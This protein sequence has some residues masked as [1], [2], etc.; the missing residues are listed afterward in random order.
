MVAFIMLENLAYNMV[1]YMVVVFWLDTEKR[2]YLFF[3]T[4]LPI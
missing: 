1:V 4:T 3:L 2:I